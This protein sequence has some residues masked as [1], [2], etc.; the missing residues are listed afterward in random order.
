MRAAARAGRWLVRAQRLSRDGLATAAE[1]AWREAATLAPELPGVAVQGALVAARAGDLR[2]AVRRVDG[3]EAGPARLFRGWLL[4]RLGRLDQSL[5][6]LQAAVADEPDNRVAA[7]ALAYAL[8]RRGRPDEATAILA[9]GPGDNL[10]LLSWAWLE[11]ERGR[12]TPVVEPDPPPPGPAAGG[13]AARRLVKAGMAAALGHTNCAWRRSSL[14]WARARSGPLAGLLRAV[15]EPLEARWPTEP[16]AA[17]LAARAGGYDS[18]ALTF[19][20]GAQLYEEGYPM[21]ALPELR[22]AWSAMTDDQE[23]YLP[24]VFLA[25]ALVERGQW[26]EAAEVLAAVAGA[27]AED[28]GAGTHEF[29]QPYWLVCRARVRLARGDDDGARRD[30]ERALESDPAV[31]DERLKWLERRD[32][33]VLK[34]ARAG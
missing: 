8:F 17:F 21:A 15:L 10:E 24:G 16:L 25:S 33:V 30:L 19:H 31:F 28:D 26:A 29:G 27:E 13:R 12:L 14:T 1:Q 34:E 20:L 4:A 11:L 32:Q 2:E 18:D 5:A 22:A 7:T 23:A 9:A 6:L 3:P